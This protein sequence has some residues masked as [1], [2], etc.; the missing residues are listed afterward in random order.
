MTT[1][2]TTPVAQFAQT[3][4]GDLSTRGDSAT[5]YSITPV[6]G[7]RIEGTVAVGVT[8]HDLDAPERYAPK[9]SHP[10][11]WIDFTPAKQGNKPRTTIEV[12]GKT[13]GAALFESV[14]GYV[15]CYPVAQYS[16]LVKYGYPVVTIDGTDYVLRFRL[17]MFD[18]VSPSA[19]R[20]MEA[21][22][23]AIAVEYLTSRRWL[24]N[25]TDSAR[26][27][28]SNAADA[29]N[30]AQAKYDAARDALSDA[31]AALNA[32]ARK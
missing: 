15:E 1:T 6:K 12:N 26:R 8:S 19:H 31:Q 14:S 24:A 11:M 5:F 21:L 17:S 23:N 28:A 30:E 18:T 3:E 7:A 4:P 9:V 22:A 2:T 10:A 25:V 29:L 32:E 13:Y 20:M 27:T 16:H